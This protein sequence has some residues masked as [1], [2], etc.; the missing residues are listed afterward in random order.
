MSILTTQLKMRRMLAY[1]AEETTRRVHSTSRD[2][3]R[4]DVGKSQSR[5]AARKVRTPPRTALVLP[6]GCCP[7]GAGARLAAHGHRPQY[8]ERLES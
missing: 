4:R 2:K 1:W 7:G 5:W 3:N 8:S 6:P